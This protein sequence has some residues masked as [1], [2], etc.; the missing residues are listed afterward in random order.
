MSEGTVD[1][2]LTTQD[3][4]FVIDANLFPRSVLDRRLF[5]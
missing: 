1:E 2:Q 5:S 3:G 4:R